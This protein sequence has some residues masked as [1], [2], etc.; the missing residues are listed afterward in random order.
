MVDRN[1]EDPIMKRDGK[2]HW[3]MFVYQDNEKKTS[4]YSGLSQ[5]KYYQKNN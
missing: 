2:L 3:Y 5:K 1:W 4:M